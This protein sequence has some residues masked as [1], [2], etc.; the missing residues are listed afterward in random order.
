MNAP[1]ISAISF[2][3]YSY[4][5]VSAVLTFRLARWNNL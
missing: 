2:V 1:G 3:P 4:M 5:R